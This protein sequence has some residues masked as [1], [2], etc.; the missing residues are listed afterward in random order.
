MQPVLDLRRERGNY[1]EYL[2]FL[3]LFGYPAFSAS[4]LLPP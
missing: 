4:K 1:P 3:M 2:I